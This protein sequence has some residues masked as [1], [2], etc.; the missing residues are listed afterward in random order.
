MERDAR[1]RFEQ[2]RKAE[3]EKTKHHGKK[4]GAHAQQ[5][6][7][8]YQPS[9]A[10]RGPPS[11]IARHSLLTSQPF[12]APSH[13][14]SARPF[15]NVISPNPQ[16]GALTNP[17][18]F[19]SPSPVHNMIGSSSSSNQLLRPPSASLFSPSPS[20]NRFPSFPLIQ[21]PNAANS[22]LAHVH[23]QPLNSLTS[24][25]GNL[26]AGRSPDISAFSPEMSHADDAADSY[27]MH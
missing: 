5:H 17:S 7:Q 13:S 14:S 21:N 3:H 16:S 1:Q 4:G 11:P 24:P 6:P 10:S 25:D 22:S 2:N 19:L 18:P 15:S 8:H 9:P 23:N 12:S 20:P 27:F 26:L